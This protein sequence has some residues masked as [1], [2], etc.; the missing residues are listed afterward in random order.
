[1]EVGVGDIWFYVIAGLTAGGAYALTALGVVV[2]Y[3]G[4][5][6]LNF[7]QGAIAMA[8]GFA[9]WELRYEQ[10]WSLP[11]ALTAGVVTGALLGAIVYGAVLR[12][13]REAGDLPR[14]IVTL[15]VLLVLQGAALL[16]YGGQ[17]TS[18]PP[19]FGAGGLTLADDGFVSYDTLAVLAAC[20][21]VAVVAAAV[22]QW[23]KF[24][25]IATA[26][27]ENAQVAATL[28]ISPHRTALV[29][30]TFGGALAGLAGCLLLP[31]TG[32]SPV[33][34]T[35]IIAP[36]M[37]VA[38]IARFRSVPVAV[39]GGLVLGVIESVLIVG[40]IQPGFVRS[41]PFAVI[42]VALVVVGSRL[43]HQGAGALKRLPR[44]GSGM[45]NWWVL[46]GG[47]A[48]VAVLSLLATGSWATAVVNS[49]IGALIA[50]AI[51]VVTG[52]AGQ[53][54]L[55]PF[56]LAGISA[57]VVAHTGG[58]LGVPFLL[59][60]LLGVAAATVVG[61]LVGLPA[62]R[63]R[64]V[65]LAIATL[66]LAYAIESSVLG[67]P[68]LTGG[69]DGL[70]VQEPRIFGLDIG[71]ALHPQRFAVFA[72][73]CVAVVVVLVAN[74][75]RGRSGRR[76]VAVRANERGAAAL[77]ISVAGAKLG[78][79][80]LS[81]AIAGLAGALAVNRFAVATFEDFTTMAS[82][83]AL[84]FV[85]VAGIGS[86]VGGVAAGLITAGGVGTLFF[87]RVLHLDAISQWLPLIMGLVV[88]D[89]MLRSPD[90]LTFQFRRQRDRV[91]VQADGPR[92]VSPEAPS[93]V[94]SGI[95]RVHGAELRVEGL[96]VRFGA[97]T[98]LEDV[99]LVVEPGTVLGVIGPNGAGKTT[100]VN[101]LSGFTGLSA[102]SVSFDGR[103]T[104]GMRPAPLARLGVHRT[105]QQ[106]ELFDD[107]TV[108]E[109]VLAGLDDHSRLAYLTDLIRPG[110][111]ELGPLGDAVVTALGLAADLESKVADLPQGRRRLVAI[112]RVVVARPTAV[113][114]D[115]PAAGLSAPERR[116]LSAVIR[117]LADDLGI[118]VLL[119]EHN[120]DVV[121]D[122]CDE[123][124][125]LNFGRVLT[126]G[127][128]A[129]VLQDPLVAE[130]Y[131]GRDADKSPS[132][133]DRLGP[134]DSQVR[135][136]PRAAAKGGA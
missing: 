40:G 18:V 35:L 53:L 85:V 120:I 88:L 61:M 14:V 51:V 126:R 92:E 2:T 105:F 128:T 100:L 65:N 8:G 17:V 24:G 43:P 84:A 47:T 125:V 36:T 44:L 86:V 98:A 127:C 118:G 93:F 90:G 27:S 124:V 122:V 108:R 64:G 78:A 7:A 94:A 107:L 68:A 80:A 130:S 104:T 116:T 59:S 46:G 37:A 82:I 34:L 96:T 67:S 4:S 42:V 113:C 134:D 31:L 119:I 30:W 117:S 23:T 6:V 71:A 22:F 76:F 136:I 97:T 110:D 49:C 45:L 13:M 131:L 101:A 95:E 87:E 72:V 132:S 52:Y 109:N 63:V 1:M 26:L 32:A 48:L 33:G 81:S 99:G 38:L 103:D 12:F 56:A 9:Y 19:V 121:S 73:V 20:V 133:D 111:H 55:A 66:G 57:L 123:L 135:E 129:D 106:L 91:P 83:L 21:V 102:G 39:A 60:I 115:E 89:M 114:L 29:T 16:R 79:F 74:A 5:G 70:R 41:V 15:G 77:G 69:V 112:A 10:D 75:R 54:N 50:L 11:A 58:E 28:G 25:A 3:R 62:V